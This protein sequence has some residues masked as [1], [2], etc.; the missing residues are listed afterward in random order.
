MPGSFTRPLA[1]AFALALVACAEQSP[2]EGA[3]DFASRADA[4]SAKC[5]V[6]T[7]DPLQV[8]CSDPAGSSLVNS[9]QFTVMGDVRLQKELAQTFL[10]A[11]AGTAGQVN[12]VAKRLF[13]PPPSTNP[14]LLIETRTLIGGMVDITPSTT[15]TFSTATVN[16]TQLPLATDTQVT[17]RMTSNAYPML[18]GTPY[19]LV[20]RV[21][22]PEVLTVG[23]AAEEDATIY[24]NGTGLE[25]QMRIVAIGTFSTSPFVPNKRDVDFSFTLD[26]GC[27]NG[28]MLTCGVGECFRSVPQCTAGVLNVCVPGNPV[29][30]TCNLKDDDCDGAVDELTNDAAGPG[31]GWTTCG[32]GICQRTV[33]NCN[34]G[35]VQTC[36]AGP[37][38]NEACNSL[39]DDCDG[40]VDELTDDA[41]GPGLHSTTCGLGVCQ[42]TTPN[43]SGGVPVTCSPDWSKQVAEACNGYDDNCD[44]M[45]DNKDAVNNKLTLAYYAGPG[46]TRN[47]LVCKDGIQT[48]TSPVNSGSAVWTITTGDVEPTAEV[49]DG[50]D[51][52]CDGT[53]DGTGGVKVKQACWPFAAGQR[54]VGVC[55]DGKQD[56]ASA[57]NSGSASWGACYSFTGPSGET[58]NGKDDDCN[59]SIDDGLGQSQCGFG[60]CT[61]AIANCSGGASQVCSPAAAQAKA[62]VC[63]GVD[64]DCNGTVDKDAGGA[65]LMQSCY[66]GPGVT[67]NVGICKDGSRSCIAPAV[68]VVPNSPPPYPG[69]EAWSACAGDILPAAEVCNNLDDD[70]DGAVDNPS[71]GLCGYTAS[72]TG[73]NCVSG[74]CTI[75]SCAAGRFDANLSYPDGCEC[76]DDASATSTGCVGPTSLGTL[77]RGASAGWSGVVPNTSLSDYFQIDFSLQAG[78]RTSY[79]GGINI[80]LSGNP[81][82]NY[83]FQILNPGCTAFG[84]CGATLDTFYF[85]DACN[86]GALNDCSSRAYP[87]PTSLV[88]RVFR[89]STT[90]GGCAG[91]SLAANYL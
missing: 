36:V 47:V 76:A 35:V 32:I 7:P 23:I 54:G 3:S 82:S 74:G 30:E 37:K 16:W 52:D 38:S 40:L 58:C 24:P 64:D 8:V 51:Q 19:A 70:C 56:C 69:T 87:F 55:L 65:T 25:R 2:S 68:A 21:Q 34:L 78:L 18:A 9:A 79:N 17:V 90:A 49:C 26:D 81:G 14:S 13:D 50:F 11:R 85:G 42:R 28:K 61:V 86:A 88:V 71:T 27:I 53:L 84:L 43:C 22:A 15:T 29:N 48:C 67:R 60:R 39:D 72:V 46:P 45:V 63:N 44:G 75:T 77:A 33:G 12:L 80:S 5:P 83:R 1:V 20:M 89:T 66:T 10:V 73:T 91:Y 31:L 41:A 4:L 59:G 6:P 57:L 62:E